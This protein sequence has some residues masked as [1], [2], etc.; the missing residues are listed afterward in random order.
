[1]PWG[2]CARMT[3]D[4]LR[5]VFRYVRSLPPVGHDTGPAMQ[6]K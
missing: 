2:A 3:D 5:S 6:C 4:D 1:M